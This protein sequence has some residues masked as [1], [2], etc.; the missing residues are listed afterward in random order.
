VLLVSTDPAS[1]IGD[2]FQQHFS[3]E[4]LP[5]KGFD[6]LWAMEYSNLSVGRGEATGLQ[7]VMNMPG[8]DELQALS[9][10]FDS[11]ERDDYDVVVFDT[12]PTGHT[13]RLLQ[14]P[15]SCESLLGSVGMFGGTALSVASQLFGGLAGEELPARMQRLQ[16][17]LANAAKRFVDP[18]QCT[19]VCVLLPEFLPLFETERLVQF[20]NDR[21][22]ESHSM[23]VNQLLPPQTQSG[24]P[25][26]FKR[27]QMQ[28][29]Y[30][31]DIRD[32][33]DDFRVI[34]VPMQV[35]EVK[36]AQGVAAFARLIAPLFSG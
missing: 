18:M 27:W 36:G 32:L 14:L 35:D 6:R 23:V 24:C 13:M 9:S 15:Q 7:S 30:L 4:P 28:Q 12:A 31:K 33:Y 22:I 16:A 1:N 3:S 20:L 8:I 2:T 21:G 5:V 11:I 34:E 26:C 17:L 10:L 25:F 29:K 19:F